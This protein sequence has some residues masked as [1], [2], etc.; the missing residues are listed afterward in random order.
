MK[1][2][3][4]IPV[5]NVEDYLQECLDSVSQ[6]VERYHGTVE[7]EIVIVDDASTDRSWSIV[8]SWG[9]EDSNVILVRHAINCGISETRNTLVSRA[10]G[11]YI[12]WVD[13]DDKVAPLWFARI[14]ENVEMHS[15]DIFAFEMT[16]FNGCENHELR[17]GRESFC[18]R[19]NDV[20]RLDAREYSMRVLQGL[21]IF[22]FMQSRVIRRALQVRFPFRTPR[23]IH[24]D[25][26]F[27]FDCLPYVRSV[28]F[29]GGSL[30]YYRIRAGSM[31]RSRRIEDY[32]AEADIL[33]EILPSMRQPYRDAAK[34]RVFSNMRRVMVAASK[35]PSSEKLTSAAVRY[36]RF[37]RSNIWAIVS[38]PYVPF[39][40][41][42]ADFVTMLPYS[43]FILKRL[44]V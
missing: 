8:E 2:S 43:S 30:Y 39:R 11:D 9:H 36:K 26:V 41:R 29:Y 19:D 5:Y 25:T 33:A 16:Q 7:H 13:S 17:Y 1:I 24:E 34:S 37:F 18:I 31:M 35:N 6:S 42:L 14:A 10:T 21:T 27:A 20:K 40:R 23:G 15:P 32:L 28:F 38:C 44:A 22:D 4:C 3:I 12:A